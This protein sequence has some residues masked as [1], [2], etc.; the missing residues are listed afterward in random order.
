MTTHLTVK[1]NEDWGRHRKG[2]TLRLPEPT[3]QTL[4]RKNIA[5][6]LVDKSEPVVTKVRR[7]PVS[8]K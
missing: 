2:Q 6:I 4:A 1:L 5:E 7:K 8:N 3:A